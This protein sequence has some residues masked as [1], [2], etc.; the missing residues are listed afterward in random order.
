[1]HARGS[2][3]SRETRVS[4]ARG[5]LRVSRF[6]RRTTGKR[7]TARSL[8]YWRTMRTFPSRGLSRKL[9]FHPLPF[10]QQITHETFAEYSERVSTTL[11][12]FSIAE[13][14]KTTES[15]NKRSKLIKASN[16]ERSKY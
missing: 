13:I 5:H 7:E 2:G 3:R 14:D 12:N 4:H 11:N 8:A 10:H 15:I 1:M 16:V 6:A 9:E